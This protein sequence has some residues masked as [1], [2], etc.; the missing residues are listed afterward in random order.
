MGKKRG[1]KRVGT[2]SETGFKRQKKRNLAKFYNLERRVTAVLRRS[3]SF[4]PFV[5]RSAPFFT[6]FSRFWLETGKKRVPKNGGTGKERT[7]SFPVSFPFPFF[8]VPCLAHLYCRGSHAIIIQ[9]DHAPLRHL[10]NQASVNACI[11]K[12]INVMQGYNLEIHH[13]PGKRNPADTL[14]RQDK[15]DAL[16]RKT[17]IHDANAD[18][19][20]ELRVPL[21]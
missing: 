1:K 2:G 4:L 13:I 11:W 16:G 20:R 5:G 6:R 14:S 12:W 19:V 17:A 18:L 7:R 21:A 8:P 9:T 15:K 3:T 10:P